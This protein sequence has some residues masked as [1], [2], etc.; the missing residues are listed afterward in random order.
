MSLVNV[1]SQEPV[2]EVQAEEGL[3]WLQKSPSAMLQVTYDKAAKSWCRLP[4]LSDG[5]RAPSSQHLEAG[6]QSTGLLL[7]TA[8]LQGHSSKEQLASTHPDNTLPRQ[9][10]PCFQ[11]PK[12]TPG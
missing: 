2:A 11:S 9:L 10:R 1:G 7:P 6:R 4:K 5:N 12:L 3:P 8:W